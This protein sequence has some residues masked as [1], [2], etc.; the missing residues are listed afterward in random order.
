MNKEILDIL[1]CPQCKGDLKIN[2]T[3]EN[4]TEIFEGQ[5]I[6]EASGLS[7]PIKNGIPNFLSGGPENS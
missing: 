5:F 7:F 2:S 3:K 4:K 1:A 6:C